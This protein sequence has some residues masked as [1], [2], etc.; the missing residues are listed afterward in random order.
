M[1][2]IKWKGLLAV[3]AVL[4][5]AA[6]IAVA[7]QTKGDPLS[8]SE[9]EITLEAYD[10][11]TLT[12][13][14]VSGEEITWK[15]S[16]ES[17]ATVTDGTISCLGKKG[18]V[19]ITAKA[20]NRS[21]KCKVL[22]VDNG[23]TPRVRGEAQTA[24]VNGTS[25][26]EVY[27]Q[28]NDRTYTNFTVG[29]IR[30]ADPSVAAAENGAIRGIAVGETT[31][32]IEL[33]WKGLTVKAREAFALSVLPE[34]V[35][36]T[37]QS[38]YSVYDVNES[39]TVKSRTTQIEAELLVRGIKDE[40]AQ[41]T[42]RG[43]GL[44]TDYT[45]D[46]LTVTA[47]NISSKKTDT[48]TIAAE[49]G[50]EEVT[51]EVTL[52]L[53]PAFD[54]RP[55]S[56]LSIA[57][58]DLG[59]EFKPET[60]TIGGR[61]GVYRYYTGEACGNA[62]NDW[63]RWG[64][65]LEVQSL[66]TLNSTSAYQ[67][68]V[69]EEGI[70]LVSFDVYYDGQTVN[71]AK[72]YRSV[73]FNA[74]YGPYSGDSVY[75]IDHVKNVPERLIV[76]GN[77]ITNT[78][79]PE[80]W[81]TFV[82]DLRELDA[83]SQIDTYISSSRTKDLTY[84]DNVR[85]WYD[86]SL[87]EGLDRSAIDLE[88]RH[89]EQNADNP[90]RY[91]APQNEFIAFSPAFTQFTLSEDGTYYSYAAKQPSGSGYQNWIRSQRKITPW[92]VYYGRAFTEGYTY[93][94]FD[95]RYVAGA[96][97][98]FAYDGALGSA[99]ERTVTLSGAVD[100][101]N[102][103]LFKDGRSLDS[104]PANEWISVVVR[105][106]AG[107]S[108]TDTLY[109][110]CDDAANAAVTKFDVRN[111]AYWTDTSWKYDGGYG[112]NNLLVAYADNFDYAIN[113]QSVALRDFI[114]ASWRGV[115]ISDYIL[116]DIEVVYGE[117]VVTYDEESGMLTI[118]T[119]QDTQSAAR[120]ADISFRISYSENDH[121]ESADLVMKIIAYPQDCLFVEQSEYMLYFG[122]NDEF[123]SERTATIGV[124]AL[125]SDGEP[126]S[127]DGVR[128]RILSGSEYITLDG[129]TVTS[130]AVGTAIVEL[131][132][133]KTDD[134]EIKTQVEVT[135]HGGTF[136][137]QWGKYETT[138]GSVTLETADGIGG[139]DGV[140]R[141]SVTGDIWNNKILLEET[142]HSGVGGTAQPA[143]VMANMAAKNYNYIAF[144]F[145]LEAG[146]TLRIEL[147]NGTEFSNLLFAAGSK[148]SYSQNSSCTYMMPFTLY[149][150]YGVQIADDST[151]SAGK[152]YTLCVPY[153]RSANS[154]QWA[155]VDMI[156]YEGS[157]LYIDNTVFA[158]DAEAAKPEGS[159]KLVAEIPDEVL[160][161]YNGTAVI[162]VNAFVAGQTVDAEVQYESL[163]ADVATCE[164]GMVT[165]LQEE[166]VSVKVTVSYN[167]QE[168]E[169]TVKVLPFVGQTAQDAWALAKKD[170]SANTFV[171][172]EGIGTFALSA[173]VWNDYL[174]LRECD[175]RLGTN[176][177]LSSASAAIAHMRDS[178]YN[179]IVFKVKVLSGTARLYA[180]TAGDGQGYAA[181]GATYAPQSGT[182]DY[183]AV[184]DAEGN[185]LVS[186]EETPYGTEYTVV[187]QYN[188]Q[189]TGWGEVCIKGSA[190]RV[191]LS[192]V[193][194]YSA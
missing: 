111:F 179:V 32:E 83:F 159:T 20:G 138:Q 116:S 168:I 75:Y 130:R 98:L 178:G 91:D 30:I 136:D 84:L 142:R 105:I 118:T 7:C 183:I 102:V 27:V 81:V 18:E 193:R 137:A 146:T 15:S 63:I 127:A 186:G 45:A 150:E 62:G 76:N 48:L 8:L 37:A 28:Y 190:C 17:I 80:T 152:W 134:Y 104:V 85:F 56:E 26:P 49:A 188:T 101:I 113:G 89:S 117:G 103:A 182:E 177:D 92:Q 41:F 67:S 133:A 65:Q 93:F 40:S 125:I 34:Y 109:L 73:S 59:A 12:V 110:S 157:N 187:M 97:K 163:N 128:A 43:D 82:V 16:D 47:G 6:G 171:V 64:S 162:S 175:G 126:M 153:D 71:D 121:T 25:V 122:T 42:V 181:V 149:N 58:P 88:E 1:K 119:P 191:E 78:L 38:V 51:A 52:A 147:P 2:R 154:N 131:Y 87:L 135:V 46:G 13:E 21:G 185:A 172:E 166:Q 106:N 144:D 57:N 148:P 167:G 53:Y 70:A 19:V 24:Y 156:F 66:K 79:V 151:V 180:P 141:Y 139:R 60:E 170:A 140:L 114:R 39:S 74:Q 164:D 68:I 3:F 23:L 96:P 112:Y 160:G 194:F 72:Q 132:Y 189:G 77:A 184:Y 100:N 11:Y 108:A 90:S 69:V 129:L 44:G 161:A 9:N 54:Q 123:A 99:E 165:F 86:D 14:G 10:D 169:K 143:D 173:D 55:T 120:E 4:A 176:P 35:I 33:L 36:E 107:A 158:Y 50:G 29:E 192:G 174:V 95:Y 22:V 31:V 124:S 145:Y 155:V 94:S 5:L 61:T 115:S